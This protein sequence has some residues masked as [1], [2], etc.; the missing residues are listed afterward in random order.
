MTR[1]TLHP[2][3]ALSERL[4]I[5]MREQH[6]Q[7]LTEFAESCGTSAATIGRMGIEFLIELVETG[8]VPAGYTGTVV[9]TLQRKYERGRKKKTAQTRRRA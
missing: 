9:Y 4:T 7:K 3:E 2:D 1:P 8:T 5:S 6:R